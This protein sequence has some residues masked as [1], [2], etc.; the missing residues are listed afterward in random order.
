MFLPDRSHTDWDFLFD[1]LWQSCTE[2]LPAVVVA[3]LSGVWLCAR[4]HCRDH[5][6]LCAPHSKR[7]QRAQEPP[8]I[9]TTA[10]PHAPMR[11]WKTRHLAALLEGIRSA[12]ERAADTPARASRPRQQKSK[13]IGFRLLSRE[14][15]L[16]RCARNWRLHGPKWRFQRGRPR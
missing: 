6:G 15:W 3:S 13:P 8:S 12:L 9:G 14:P 2:R 10:S 16:S 4:R 11:S 5:C 1:I 7:R